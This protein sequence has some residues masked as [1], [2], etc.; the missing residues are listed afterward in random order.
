MHPALSLFP[1]RAGT[2]VVALL[3]LATLWML[4]LSTSLAETG[5]AVS[6]QLNKLETDNDSCRA[7][8]V[9][10]NRSPA[11]FE[12]LRLD[13]V[14]FD[15]DGVIARRLAVDAAPLPTGKTSVRVFPIAGLACA[16][17]GRLLLNDVIACQDASGERRDCLEQ[18]ETDSI[19]GV[20]FI[21]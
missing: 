15:G 19:A 12:S 17:I 7:Y 16:D 14:I 8:L 10:E 4:P 11:A 3:F 6:V 13:V 18:M 2:G 20:P 1:N 21:K 5:Q 9:L